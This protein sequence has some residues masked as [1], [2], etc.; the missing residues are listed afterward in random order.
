MQNVTYPHHRLVLL[1]V[2]KL[3][4]TTVNPFTLWKGPIIFAAVA[5]LWASYMLNSEVTTI[6]YDLSTFTV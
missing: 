3:E 6:S 1:L 2:V 5:L 4:F